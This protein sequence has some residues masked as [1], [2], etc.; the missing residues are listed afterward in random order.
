M[1]AWK[2]KADVRLTE[3][4]RSELD[5]Q[6]PFITGWVLVATYSDD[7]GDVCTAFNAMDGQR[8][9]QTL[10]ML[11]HALEVERANIFWDERPDE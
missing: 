1:N 9:T 11:N 2:E 5:E 8:R 3:V 4:I 10:G 7:E 6:A